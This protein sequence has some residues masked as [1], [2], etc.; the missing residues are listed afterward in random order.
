MLPLLRPL[1]VSL[2]ALVASCATVSARAQ[3]ISIEMQGTWH[4]QYEYLGGG[5]NIVPIA[6]NPSYT[7]T[8]VF[9]IG[10]PAL[11][12]IE[13]GKSYLT[14]FGQPTMTSIATSYGPPNNLGVS[15]PSAFTLLSRHD[16]SEPSEA[17]DPFQSYQFVNR[18]YVWIDQENRTLNWSY[19]LEFHS[20]NESIELSELQIAT[21][22]EFLSILTAAQNNSMPFYTSFWKYTFEV[23]STYGPPVTYTGGIGLSGFAHITSISIVPEPPIHLQLVAGAILFSVAFSFRRR[24]AA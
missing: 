23:P 8:L 24:H 3:L 10:T 17:P 15:D 2:V 7:V 9:D 1:T 12:F 4:V 14:E 16:Y 22:G 6:V 13:P 18:D 21:A 5:A 20:P 19:G 11:W